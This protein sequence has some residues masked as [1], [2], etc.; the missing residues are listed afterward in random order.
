PL[1]PI[2]S[3]MGAVRVVFSMLVAALVV[4]WGEAAAHAF[5]GAIVVG[6]DGNEAVAGS[7]IAW[8]VPLL[9]AVMITGWVALVLFA[10]R[11]GR[12]A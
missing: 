9:L 12:R 5:H 11:R 4:V 7:T 1:V 2:F 8:T 3:A 6:P 10:R